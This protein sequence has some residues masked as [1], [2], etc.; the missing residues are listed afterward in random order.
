MAR[1]TE[2]LFTDFSLTVAVNKWLILPKIK[3]FKCQQE[4]VYFT[5]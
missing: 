5:R 4:L 2:L 3:A 1:E